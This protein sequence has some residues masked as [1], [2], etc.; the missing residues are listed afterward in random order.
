MDKT[1]ISYSRK[2]LNFA[3]RILNALHN[4]GFNP[5]F[6][7]EDLQPG[8]PWNNE[9]L[10]G[11]QL[12]DNLLFIISPDSVESHACKEELECALRH[13]K[14]LIPL[15]YK[16]T[17]PRF[18]HPALRELQWVFLRDEDD[19]ERGLSQLIKVI[20]SPRGV[21]PLSDRTSAEVEVIDQEGTRK[22]SLQRSSYVIGRKPVGGAESGVIVIYDSTRSVSRCHVKLFFDSGFW[23]AR[24][25][26]RNGIIFSP[27]CSSGRLENETKI[28]LGP[29]HIIFREISVKNFPDPDEFPTFVGITQNEESP[30]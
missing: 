13:G 20:D 30:P 4:R 15:L 1:F 2:D 28:I 11:V 26:S 8:R 16:E 25:Q 6:D 27:P 24:D 3:R 29:A 21:N 22:I 5:W 23:V 17:S 12:A 7:L 10:L 14:R 18:L 19:F 9:M